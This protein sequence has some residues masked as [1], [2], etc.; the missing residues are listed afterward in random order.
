MGVFG[1]IVGLII[2][3]LTP[4]TY[5]SRTRMELKP[6]LASA[7][8]IVRPPTFFERVCRTVDSAATRVGLP[9]P[10][11]EQRMTRTRESESNY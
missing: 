2:A 8:L 1:I 7:D 6:D 4:K 11:L 5:Y 3:L 9:N 10:N